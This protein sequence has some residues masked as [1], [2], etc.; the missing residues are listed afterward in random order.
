MAQGARRESPLLGTD[1]RLEELERTLETMREDAEL[2]HVLLGLSGA[3]ADVRSAPDTLE[4]AVQTAAE[5]LGADRCLA[6]GWDRPGGH[7]NIQAHHGFDDALF[8]LADDLASRPDGLRLLQTALETR[9][10]VFVPDVFNDPRVNPELAKMRALGAYIGI[11]LTRWG[12]ELGAL[13]LEYS[14]PRTFTTKEMALARGIAQPLS[15]ALSN[16]RQ[17]SLLEHLRTLGLQ[18]GSKLRLNV[19]IEEV[20]SGATSLVSADG[21]VLFFLDSTHQTLVAAGVYGVRPADLAERLARLQAREEPWNGVFEGRTVV[22]KDLGAAMGSVGSGS[23]AVLVP[24]PGADSA[25]TG[26]LLIFFG[27]EIQMGPDE[28]GALS[29]FAIQSG[30]AI[31]NARRYERQRGVARSLQAGLLSTDTPDLGD[32]QVGMVYEPANEEADV[33]GDFFDIFDLS[34]DRVAIVVGDVSGKGAEAAAQTAMAK[35]MLRAFAIRNPAPSSVLFHLNNAL[36]QGMDEDR[37]ATVVY[38]VFDRTTHECVI[39]SAGH[40]PPMVYRSASKDVETIEVA[41]PILGAFPEQSYEQMTL[42]LEPDDTLLAYTDG[43]METR[44]GNEFYGMER[45]ADALARHA[46]E[47]AGILLARSLYE[48]AQS[49]GQ[50]S[51]DTVVFALSYRQAT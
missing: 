20:V 33:G 7:F 6:A 39:A 10:V 28:T 27:S 8:K 36:A 5:L 34:D 21:A 22:I 4:I 25:L 32:C 45:V 23:S 18:I 14:Q 13:A 31:E 29:I 26:A 43:L 48:E 40:P 1:S 50:V 17:F 19:V 9:E 46:P 2:T 35:Y 15:V 41:G 12:T 3:L 49:F 24:I 47:S 42:R 37:F 16:A 11:P 38:G 30:T 51:D 44:S